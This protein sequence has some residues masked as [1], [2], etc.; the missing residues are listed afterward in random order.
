M[1]INRLMGV[2]I[3]AG[4]QRADCCSVSM[5]CVSP[6][7]FICRILWVFV[8]E[9]IKNAASQGET[10]LTYDNANVPELFK[11]ARL[12]HAVGCATTSL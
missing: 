4:N 10:A 9:K 6:F 2:S 12:P 5:C 7:V 8:P 1:P 3:S 11:P